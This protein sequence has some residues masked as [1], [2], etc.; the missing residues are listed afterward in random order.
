MDSKVEK[1]SVKRAGAELE[2]EKAKKQKLDENVEIEADDSVELKSYLEIVHEDE[3]DVTVDTTPLSS[4]SPS[5]IDYKIHKEG[6]KNY[7]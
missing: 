5:I 3:D 4:K 7:F 6:K 2:Q 1:S